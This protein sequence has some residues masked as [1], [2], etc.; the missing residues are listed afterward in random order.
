MNEEN[1]TCEKC[2]GGKWRLKKVLSIL[3]VT[4]SVFVLVKIVAGIESLKYI[5]EPNAPATINVSGTGE[6][7][8]VPDIAN[9]NFSVTEES[10][11]VADAQTK[12]ASTT[13]AIIAYLKQ[14][15]VLGADVQTTDYSI[16][17]RYN[18][19]PSG[20]QEL[21][22]YDVSESVSVN[23]KNISSVGS[24]LSG[25]GMLGAENVSDL[26]FTEDNYDD[27]VKQTEA[28]AITDAEMN[29]ARIAKDLGVS[30][31]RITAYSNQSAVLPSPIFYAQAM[32]AAASP[33]VS[34]VISSG[35]NKITANVTITYEIQ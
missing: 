33:S 16:N 14:N 7:D 17:P 20:I 3:A 13:N 34:P 23:V 10:D 8:A 27:L 32:S 2:Y 5:G 26:S 6:I 9:F 28:K 31:G 15:G 29:A 21:A 24:L 12:A 25:I 4:L 30:L 18:Y 19:S 1:K 35:Q 11:D 22:G